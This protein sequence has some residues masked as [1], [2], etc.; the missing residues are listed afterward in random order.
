MSP[1]RPASRQNAIDILETDARWAGK[2]WFNLFDQRIW[3]GDRE[4]DDHMLTDLVVDMSRVAGAE[5][6]R[7]R[8]YQAVS[9]VARRRERHAVAT[10][11]RALCWDG[12][13]RL[14]RLLSHYFCA[15]TDPF[16]ALLGRKWT[17]SAVSRA[18][19]PGN[20]VDTTLLLVGKQGIRKSCAIRALA[21]RPEWFNDTSLDIGSRDG[22]LALLGTWLMELG[23]LD[24]LERSQLSAIK[25]FLTD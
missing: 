24:S 13:A 14:D 17:I 25:A 4:L 5:F 1:S 11:L 8:V 12:M 16:T 15:E 9:Y 7:D 2:L 10:Y 20:K 21:V 19:K 23:E 22:R 3:L 18:L 6:T